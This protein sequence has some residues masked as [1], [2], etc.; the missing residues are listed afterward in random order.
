MYHFEQVSKNTNWDAGVEKLIKDNLIIG[1][2]E[3]AIDCA[4][5]CGR[6]AEALLLA[7]SQGSETFEFTMNTFLT[8]QTDYFLKNVLKNIVLK[9]PEDIAKNYELTTWKE[10]AAIVLSSKKD[11]KECEKIIQL[12]GDR[13]LQEKKDEANALLCF[14]AGKNTDKCINIYRNQLK[15]LNPKS[16]LYHQRLVFFIKS[17]LILEQLTT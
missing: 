13:F 4:L 11:M 15:T 1:N 10:C 17:A 9:K 5:K 2:Y 16:A 7:Y 14:I 6:S 3:G 8:A 12:L